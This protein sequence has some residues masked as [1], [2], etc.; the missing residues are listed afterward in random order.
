M[1]WG[2]FKSYEMKTS[3]IFLGGIVGG[4]VFFLLGWLIYGM[5]LMD[6][7]MANFNQCMN[8]PMADMIMWAIALSN[9]A[10]GFLLAF[11]FKWA[12]INT[13]T[14]GT[15]VAATIGFLMVVSIDLSFYSMTT[16]YVNTSAIFVDVITYTVMVA[17]TGAAVAWVMNFRKKEV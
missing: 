15:K 1:S 6:F 9:F 10:L 3:K 5:L 16:M 14:S 8:R 7:A 12:N 13:I 2:N 4:I 11:V 17:I